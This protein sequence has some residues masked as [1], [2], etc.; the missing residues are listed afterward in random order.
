MLQNGI[1]SYGEQWSPWKYLVVCFRTSWWIHKPRMISGGFFWIFSSWICVS[2][3]SFL[4]LI[5]FFEIVLFLCHLQNHWLL[6]H[7]VIIC[8]TKMLK[9]FA[10]EI[11]KTQI[12]IAHHTCLGKNSPIWNTMLKIRPMALQN[13]GRGGNLWLGQQMSRKLK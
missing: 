9:E 7:P 6:H 2:C 12:Y 10:L 5:V 11:L 1:L 3:V 13:G 4:S 8:N